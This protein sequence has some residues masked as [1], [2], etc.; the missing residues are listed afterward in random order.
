MVRCHHRIPHEALV[1]WLVQTGCG[2]SYRDKP[3]FGGRTGRSIAASE[4]G[5]ERHNMT[6]REMLWKRVKAAMV[7]QATTFL[8]AVMAAFTLPKITNLYVAMI[9]VFS[10]LGVVLAMLYRTPC[11]ACSYPIAMNGP[12]N[13]RVGAG[14]QRINYCPHCGINIDEDEGLRSRQ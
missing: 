8:L 1:G 6:I 2:P 12:I 3:Q 13:L 5:R 9:L 11:P 4:P 14:A 7:V 10:G